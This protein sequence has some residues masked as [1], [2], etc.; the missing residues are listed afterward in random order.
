MRP[1]IDPWVSTNDGS[2]RQLELGNF[3][4]HALIFKRVLLDKQNLFVV[5]VTVDVRAKPDVAFDLAGRKIDYGFM[6]SILRR[7]AQVS[8]NMTM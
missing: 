4:F 2:F 6:K 5:T 8:V 1:T 7:S 3:R